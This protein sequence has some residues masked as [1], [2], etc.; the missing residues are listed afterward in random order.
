M[1]VSGVYSLQFQ[2]PSDKLQPLDKQLC[3]N[4]HSKCTAGLLVVC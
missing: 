1:K 3:T 2:R 4:F